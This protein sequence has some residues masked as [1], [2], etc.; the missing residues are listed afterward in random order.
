MATITA[1]IEWMPLSGS[2]GY[3]VEYK[4]KSSDT[5]LLANPPNPTLYTYYDLEVEEGEEYDG[6][7]SSVCPS[8]S[9]YIFFDIL[10]PEPT[11][12]LI[13]EEDT[14]QCTQS[15][16]AFTL[17]D[18]YTGFSS[19]QALFYDDTTSR[20]YVVDSDDVLGNLWYFNPNTITGFGSATHV[21]GLT[22]DVNTWVHDPINR[23]IIVAGDQ[24]GGAYILNIA[25]NT[26]TTLVYGTN[27][28]A[29]SGRRAPLALSANF[30]YAFCSVP[31]EIYIYNRS[32][33]AAVSTVTKASITNNT[34]YLVNGYSVIFVGSEIWVPATA[35]ANSGIA[36]YS[37]DFGS[38]LGV[39]TLPS[40]LKPVSPWTAGTSFF[41]QT[42]YYDEANNRL[43]IADIGSNKL[44]TINTS[45]QAVIN[46]TDIV[47][48]RGKAYAISSF[49]KNEL[50]G[51]IYMSCHYVDDLTDNVNNYKLYTIDING[52]YEYVYPDQSASTLKLRTGTNE[53]WGVN[54][55][56][57]IWDT[58]NTGW[59]TDGLV[60]KY[61]Q[62]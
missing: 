5:W 19:P 23:R 2:N 27:T 15:G 50:D 10:P 35:R 32:T 43:Y 53:L 45:T 58:P 33:L 51:K 13:W 38:F 6:R 25:T 46:T 21:A 55:G 16:N 59:G 4:L 62:S 47:N 22:S 49:F 34:T 54:A 37:S 9:K 48:R 56:R 52:D 3:T 7:I 30:I 40:A 20:F 12:I 39:I 61:I 26:F 14:Y 31:N 57:V 60:L 1:H 41:W 24:T 29:G 11:P 28:T 42:N 44:F 18:T 36:R 17:D 8:G